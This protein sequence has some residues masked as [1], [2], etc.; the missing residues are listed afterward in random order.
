MHGSS[1]QLVTNTSHQRRSTMRRAPTVVGRDPMESLKVPSIWKQT[2]SLFC[3]KTN[4]RGKQ[5]TLL[6]ISSSMMLQTLFLY[7]VAFPQLIRDSVLV[8]RDGRLTQ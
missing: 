7:P 8:A 5:Y 1:R 4:G 3:S 6:W 2:A